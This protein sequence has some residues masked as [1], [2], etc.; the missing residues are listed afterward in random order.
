MSP[1]SALIAFQAGSFAL[2][3]QLLKRQ[4]PQNKGFSAHA[5]CVAEF[6]LPL[7]LPDNRRYPGKTKALWLE[8]DDEPETAFQ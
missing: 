7:T 4:I 6:K 8:T 1:Q 3:C 2:I 5:C